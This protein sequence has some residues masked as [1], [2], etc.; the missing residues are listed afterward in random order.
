LRD[1]QQ[2]IVVSKRKMPQDVVFF[3]GRAENPAFGSKGA[4]GHF[5]L[6]LERA[7]TIR[8]GVRQMGRNV[9]RVSR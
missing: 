1:L 9:G 2:D 8:P 5:F 7:K 3:L 6:I 4:K